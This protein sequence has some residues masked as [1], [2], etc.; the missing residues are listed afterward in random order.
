MRTDVIDYLQKEIYHRCKQPIN[1]FGILNGTELVPIDV[2][3]PMWLWSRG[4]FVVE[5]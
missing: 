5:I 3:T 1:K 2:Y 4:K